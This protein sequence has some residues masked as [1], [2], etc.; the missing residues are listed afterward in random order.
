MIVEV[1]ALGGGGRGV[2][3]AGDEVWFVSDGL[4][5]ERVEAVP[6]RRRAGVVEARARR[7]ETPSPW[8]D[9][10]PCPVAA[11]CGGCDLAHVRREF[12]AEA[13]RAVVVGA[14]R[15]A[16]PMLA[17][18]LGGAPV[19]VSPMGWRLRARLHWSARDRRLGFLAGKSHRVVVIDPCRVVSDT[20]LKHLPSLAGALAA[21]RAPDG[22]VE[23]LESL[24]GRKAVAGW[25]GPGRQPTVGVEDLGGWHRIGRDG[26]VPGRGWGDDG[27]TLELPVP[28]WVP[29]GAFAQG[30]RFLLPALFERVASLA[31]ASGCR[32]AVDLYGGVGLLGAAAQAGGVEEVAI[33]ESHRGAVAAAARN[34]PAADVRPGRAEDYLRKPPPARAAM[35]IVDPPRS[36]LTPEAVGA[37][38]TWRPEVVLY[39]SCDAARF[40]RDAGR[41]LSSGYRIEL[42]EIWDLF[43]GSHH[44][45]ILS[46]F[47]R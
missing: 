21:S 15:H 11:E 8:R 31:R 6:E 42:A 44:A 2:A 29:L 22:E 14:L 19:V 39:L 17:G 24:D 38:A 45:E 37:L 34:C 41:L 9:P 20:L 3:R 26:P 7:V 18:A 35:A 28:L 13:L 4:P 27:I 23:W 33:V 1:T 12:A 43:A 30:N 10:D 36:G 16:P 5:G 40:G 32:F 47:R 25:R 46:V